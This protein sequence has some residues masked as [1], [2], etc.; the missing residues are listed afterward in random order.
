M[1]DHQNARGGATGIDLL[2]LYIQ[3]LRS[4]LSPFTSESHTAKEL[5]RLLK[6]RLWIAQ[7]GQLSPL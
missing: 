7:H 6:D 3:W 2:A 4:A 1:H 5:C